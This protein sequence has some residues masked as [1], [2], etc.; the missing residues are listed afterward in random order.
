M[1]HYDTTGIPVMKYGLGMFWKYRWTW[2]FMK[3]PEIILG[4]D[5]ACFDSTTGLGTLWKYHF[6][7]III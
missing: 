5:L 3:V 4:M 6:S 1:A 7:Q 2:H